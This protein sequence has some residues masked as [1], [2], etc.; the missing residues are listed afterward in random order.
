M[1]KGKQTYKLPK[2]WIWTNVSE[3]FA[4][5]GGGTPTKNNSRYWGGDINWASVKDVKSQFISST[6]DKITKEGYS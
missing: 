3:L 1:E 6:I 4:I 5:I 2:G